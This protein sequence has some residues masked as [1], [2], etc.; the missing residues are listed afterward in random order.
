[1]GGVRTVLYNY[2]FAKKHGGT[3]ILRIEDTDRNRFLGGA[4]EYIYSCLEWCGLMPDE[5][6]IAGGNYRSILPR[7]GGGSLLLPVLTSYRYPRQPPPFYRSPAR[8]PN[9]AI[10]N[11]SLQ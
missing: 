1:V 10:P 11:T 6:T 7:E 5:S 9:S 8:S 2:L 4:E 3:F